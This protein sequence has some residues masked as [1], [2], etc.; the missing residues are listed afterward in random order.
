ML[1]S[2]SSEAYLHFLNMDTIHGVTEVVAARAD[3]STTGP[4]STGVEFPFGNSTQSQFYV[5]MDTC[6]GRVFYLHS[7]KLMKCHLVGGNKWHYIIW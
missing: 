2:E 1:F 3:D 6:T 4:V 5:R 7:S